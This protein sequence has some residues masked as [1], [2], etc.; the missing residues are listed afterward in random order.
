[1]VLPSFLC[2]RV[3]L[4]SLGSLCFRRCR[5]WVG[6]P[7]IASSCFLISLTQY[8]N[9]SPSA[10]H[11][12]KTTGKK[13]YFVSILVSSSFSLLSSLSLSF[14]SFFSPLLSAFHYFSSRSWGASRTGRGTRSSSSSS[15]SFIHP[16]QNIST[17]HSNKF[18][19]K[20]KF[21]HRGLNPNRLERIITN[22]TTPPPSLP[23]SLPLSL[24]P[25]LKS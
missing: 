21:K 10:P 24:P 19:F 9:L 14:V 18:S 2:V 7:S 25:S 1:M 4:L 3:L 8:Y 16:L 15:S 17:S 23:P 5:L 6:N 22:S 11:T 20:I 12:L 13:Y